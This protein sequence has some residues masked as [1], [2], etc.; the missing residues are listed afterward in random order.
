MRKR[1]KYGQWGINSKKAIALVGVLLFLVVGITLE[2]CA[3]GFYNA[4]VDRTSYEASMEKDWKKVIEIG[5]G[6][7]EKGIDFFYLRLRK[8]IA[9]DNLEKFNRSDLEYKK[10][11][12]FFPVD[13][14]TYWYRY[15]ALMNSG[16]EAEARV[17]SPKLTSWQ[18]K[19]SGYK[20][21]RLNNFGLEAGVLLGK[22]PTTI[23][24]N[25]TQVFLIQRQQGNLF[26]ASGNGNVWLGKRLNF[27][28]GYM[29][30]NVGNTVNFAYRPKP[31]GNS[32]PPKPEANSWEFTTTQNAVY[33]GLGYQFAKGWSVFAAGNFIPYEGGSI[34]ITRKNS[35]GN[36]SYNTDKYSFSGLDYTIFAQIKKR[37]SSISLEPSYSMNMVSNQVYHQ[38]NF[39]GTSYPLGNNRLYL[40]GQVSL[41]NHDSTNVIG[42]L[43]VGVRLAKWIWTEGN[44]AI[45]K[46]YGSSDAGGWILNNNPDQIAWKVGLNLS[47]ILK[48]RIEVPLRFGFLGREGVATK[49]ENSPS[50]D[51]PQALNE[52]YTYGHIL[53]NTGIKIYF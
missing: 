20:S 27:S 53:I 23:I 12:A 40:T 4:E 42:G 31:S 26:F 3:Q 39:A 8:G 46:M 2:T 7:Q 51:S 19:Y 11:N 52:P 41:L 36:F 9:Y 45:G 10:A 37:W 34:E 6:A 22:A 50:G 33:L 24:N 49:E 15:V 29:F 18:R 25:V 5:E 44:F 17:L 1:K 28:L 14:L 32:G 16:R 21:V 35:N 30:M 43:K 38:M 48:N 13:T 47:F